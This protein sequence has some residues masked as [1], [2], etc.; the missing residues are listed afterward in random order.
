MVGYSGADDREPL[1]TQ[2]ATRF[3]TGGAFNGGTNLIVW[4]DPEKPGFVYDCPAGPQGWYPL[5]QS[6]L[7]IFDEEE[8][9][10]I[11]QVFPIDPPP[12]CL[13][14]LSIPAPAA[15]NL[16]PVNSASL[17]VPFYFGWL[18]F[19][20]KNPLVPA[21]PHAQSSLATIVTTPGHSAVQTTA[22]ALD[23][24]CTPKSCVPGSGAVRPEIKS[25]PGSRGSAH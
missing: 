9:V 23:S 10:A 17:P 15:T 22:T 11:P 7:T 24:A 1:A 6:A 12:S 5:Y 16:V 19:D 21:D 4:R 20:F 3:V 14:C 13:P 18:F 25:C 2:W 8:H